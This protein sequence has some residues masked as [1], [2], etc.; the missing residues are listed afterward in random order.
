MEFKDGQPDAYGK[1]YRFSQAQLLA[2]RP[3]D[4]VRWMCRDAFGTPEPGPE[5][6]PTERRSS[7][8]A[9]AKKAVSYFMPNK[10]MHWNVETEAGN[11]TKSVAVNEL[12]KQV[13]KLE[14]RKQGK[15]SNAKRV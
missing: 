13:K 10:H 11:P 4:I 12:I 1:G 5:D 3:I 6:K 9:F 8:L 2:I 7:G 14:V 15:P